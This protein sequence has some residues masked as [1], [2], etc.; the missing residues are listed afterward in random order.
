M[1]QQENDE[2]QRA[3]KGKESRTVNVYSV[4][5]TWRL[6]WEAL[7]LHVIVLGG[8]QN[9]YTCTHADTHRKTWTWGKLWYL[10]Y[11]K[12][13]KTNWQNLRGLQCYSLSDL[14]PGYQDLMIMLGIIAGTMTYACLLKYYG[15]WCINLVIFN[16]DMDRSALLIIRD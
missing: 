7:L 15:K 9:N 5:D 6:I 13:C 16:T 10:T 8:N 11:V 1:Q 2:M 3:D 12:L 4:E 14:S